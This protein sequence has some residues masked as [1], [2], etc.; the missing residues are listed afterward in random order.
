M[1]LHQLLLEYMLN[2]TLFLLPIIIHLHIFCIL[3]HSNVWINNLDISLDISLCVWFPVV[4]HLIF[5]VCELTSWWLCY[6]LYVL[7]HIHT[8][9][10]LLFFDDGAIHAFIVWDVVLSLDN[11]RSLVCFS[12]VFFSLS[13]K[14]T[15]FDIV[16]I[17]SG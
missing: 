15:G 9:V 16:C 3:T 12:H 5:M 10:S 4:V 6:V 8:L 7:L 11:L 14:L 2:Q 13:L 1:N 17:F